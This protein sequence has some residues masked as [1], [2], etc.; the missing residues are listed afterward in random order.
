MEEEIKTMF[1][2]PADGE[3]EPENSAMGSKTEEASE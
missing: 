1:D 3:Q 2:E